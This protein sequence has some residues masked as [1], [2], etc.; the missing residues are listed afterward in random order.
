MSAK[1]WLSTVTATS[2]LGLTGTGG[3]WWQAMTATA[4][5]REV[6]R[7]RIGTFIIPLWLA[8]RPASPYLVRPY[9]RLAANPTRPHSRPPD[10]AARHRRHHHR[11]VAA[12]PCGAHARV[13]SRD[14]SVEPLSLAQGHHLCRVRTGSH[15]RGPHLVRRDRGF[16]HLS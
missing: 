9:D 5:S 15:S 16:G 13:P 12:R 10:Q 6:R 11:V 14:R 3:P 7:T 8:P 4:R 2:A 1:F